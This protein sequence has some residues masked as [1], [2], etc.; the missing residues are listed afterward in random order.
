MSG[1]HLH[2]LHITERFV[3]PTFA[4]LTQG[5]RRLSVWFKDISTN[6]AVR[7]NEQFLCPFC[8]FVCFWSVVQGSQT[9]NKLSA[10]LT[11]RQMV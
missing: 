9:A 3:F 10:A 5:S 4:A 1:N 8:L 6:T 11:E 7:L 2:N